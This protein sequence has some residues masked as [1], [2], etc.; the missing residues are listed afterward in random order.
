[1]GIFACKINFSIKLM[2]VSDRSPLLSLG[3]MSGLC[4]QRFSLTK[5]NFVIKDYQTKLKEI[6]DNFLLACED[7]QPS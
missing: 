5:Y 2:S 4:P 1:M 3:V 6:T 7:S